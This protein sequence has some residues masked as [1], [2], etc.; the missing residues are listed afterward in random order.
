MVGFLIYRW[1]GLVLFSRTVYCIMLL[2]GLRPE[3]GLGSNG[4]G[5]LCDTGYD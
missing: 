1:R 4:W 5:G 2:E 3:R